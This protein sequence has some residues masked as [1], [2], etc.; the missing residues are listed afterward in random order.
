MSSSPR[1][2]GDARPVPPAGASSPTRCGRSTP[3]ARRRPSARR[4]GAA[5]TSRTSAGS[6]RRGSRDPRMPST[7][8]DAGLASVYDR[9][10]WRDPD[11]RQV[12]L[13]AALGG[14][15][16]QPRRP[17]GHRDARRRGRARAARSPSPIAVTGSAATTCAASSTPGW[18]TASSSRPCARRSARCST[19]P[20]GCASRAAPSSC[21][22]PPPRWG[23]CGRCCAGAPRSPPSTCPVPTCGPGCSATPAGWPV[24]CSCPRP[25]AATDLAA[26][27]RGRPR[28]RPADR[29]RVGLR[30][31]RVARHR[32]LRLR[33]RRH[34]R[35]GQ[36]RRRRPDRDGAPRRAPTPRCRSSPPRPTSSPCPVRPST[37]RRRPTPTAAPRR[38]CAGRC[39]PCRAV[40]CC[41]ATTCPARTPA[42]T[43]RVVLQQGPNYLLAKRLQRWRATS[44][45]AQG[46][47]VSFK[48]APPTRTRSVVKNRGLAAAYAGAHR[49]GVEVFDPGTANTLM[50]ALLVHDLRR[51]LAAPGAP[52]A[53]RG[54]CRGAR[55]AVARG[56]RPAQRPGPG[57]PARR[58][59]RPPLTRR[60][61]S[62]PPVLGWVLRWSSEQPL[63]HPTR[64]GCDGSVVMLQIT[65][66]IRGWRSRRPPVMMEA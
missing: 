49:F 16:G 39:A 63:Q 66:G 57:G 33:R 11:G 42:S 51:R 4:A 65:H 25:R 12:R 54:V 53:G 7:I 41:A 26:A 14:V 60:P 47:T 32:Q 6:S 10:R 59:L 31:A 34:Q 27:R 21:S 64:C 62:L 56:L 19:T 29:H 3:S 48:I 22:A 2:T 44:A 52:V 1:S 36:H 55:R 5:A 17:A 23:R 24:G 38:C 40:A 43:T 8:A 46:A 58:R 61:A 20:S 35:A 37:P 18:P 50:A 30:A 15:A 28:P 45:R 9:M 13:E